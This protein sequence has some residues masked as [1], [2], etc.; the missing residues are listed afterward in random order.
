MKSFCFS[1]NESGSDGSDIDDFDTA[2]IFKNFFESLE[3]KLFNFKFVRCGVTAG[4]SR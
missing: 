1:T 3:L 4:Y 2:E